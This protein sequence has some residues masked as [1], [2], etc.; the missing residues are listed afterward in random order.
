MAAL[1]IFNA[2]AIFTLNQRPGNNKDYSL[3]LYYEN[4]EGRDHFQWV[5]V[6]WFLFDE[7]MNEVGREGKKKGRE[8]RRR[9]ERNK[10]GEDGEA[11]ILF[12][13]NE[14][15]TARWQLCAKAGEWD[16]AERGLVNQ[17]CCSHTLIFSPLPPSISP[18]PQRVSLPLKRSFSLPRLNQRQLNTQMYSSSLGCWRGNIFWKIWQLSITA[19]RNWRKEERATKE[20]LNRIFKGHS[21]I[22]CYFPKQY[23]E[24][25]KQ[26][27]C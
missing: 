23:F 18:V 13:Y 22:L 11:L 14:R 24:I 17:P 16:P 10:G 8:G 7:W 2:Y 19:Q 1:R 9:E 5:L 12:T 25:K 20:A 27:N 15:L 4:W 3:P 6:I 21:P 26:T